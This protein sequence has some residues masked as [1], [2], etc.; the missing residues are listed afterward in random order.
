M[1]GWFTRRATGRKAT[2]NRQIQTESE[3][4]KNSDTGKIIK[5]ATWMREN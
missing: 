2:G 4:M 1:R 5:F 3:S